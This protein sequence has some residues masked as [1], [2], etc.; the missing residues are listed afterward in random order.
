MKQV[1]NLGPKSVA[2]LAEAG[3]VDLDQLARR[4]AVD[5]FLDVEA[6]GRRPSLNLLYAMEGAI[7]R[8]HWQA[9]RREEGGELNLRLEMARQA[10]QAEALNQ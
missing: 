1:I 7:T 3:I 9:V 2:W 6:S 10:R 5:A 8:R 4:G